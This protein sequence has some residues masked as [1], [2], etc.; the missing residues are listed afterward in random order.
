[1]E[2]GQAALDV[3]DLVGIETGHVGGE[4]GAGHV[5]PR[6]LFGIGALRIADQRDESVRTAGSLCPHTVGGDPER[7]E[8]CQMAG[9]VNR[10]IP[11][12]S[13]GRTQVVH[14][15]LKHRMPCSLVDVGWCGAPRARQFISATHRAASA[16]ACSVARALMIRSHLACSTRTCGNTWPLS[17][18][19]VSCRLIG[20]LTRV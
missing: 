1:M 3:D 7:L 11:L 9:P 6:E 20:A 10:R 17:A 4:V 5:L 19:A 13:I 2:S 14:P 12:E 15:E 18:A 8:G 16:R